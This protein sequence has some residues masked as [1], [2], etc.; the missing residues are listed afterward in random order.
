MGNQ[1]Y[2]RKTHVKKVFY[3][4]F[5]ERQLPKINSLKIDVDIKR[6][7]A[8]KANIYQ[9]IFDSAFDNVF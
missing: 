9:G 8:K 2:H 6:R 3:P 7:N 4:A 1:S 5:K